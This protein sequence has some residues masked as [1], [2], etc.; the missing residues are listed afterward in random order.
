[1]NK[2]LAYFFL[3][4]LS[5]VLC[6]SCASSPTSDIESSKTTKHPQ[7]AETKKIIISSYLVDDEL[8]AEAFVSRA[9]YV[10]ANPPP[11]TSPGLA[12]AANIFGAL[13]TTGITENSALSKAKKQIQALNQKLE[14]RNIKFNY[15]SGL[16][17][18]LNGNETPGVEL[19]LTK[20]PKE[21]IKE[22]NVLGFFSLETRYF[23]DSQFSVLK[24]ETKIY[25][26]NKKGRK[27]QSNKIK[28][29]LT[30]IVYISDLLPSPEESLRGDAE[31]VVQHL[32][33]DEN[34]IKLIDAI[35]S[36]T[37]IVHKHVLS[38]IYDRF[39]RE[40]KDVKL[41]RIIATGQN[42]EKYRGRLLSMDG[43]RLVLIN[44][45]SH[46][47]SIKPKKIYYVDSEETVVFQPSSEW[48]SQAS[49][50][51]N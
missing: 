34:F 45:V 33:L 29:P 1:M 37:K 24:I 21:F 38:S 16:S 51:S 5:S 26:Y 10:G 7:V 6:L 4:C 13:L 22:P 18:A 23:L 15:A 12:V 20:E 9:N 50:S 11:G 30:H 47:F 19:I 36:G 14:D 43:E 8:S 40:N 48:T 2:N 39:F 32:C 35:D 42:M 31:A 17:M 28:Q 49:D 46:I 44:G 27:S 41:R 3:I 25:T